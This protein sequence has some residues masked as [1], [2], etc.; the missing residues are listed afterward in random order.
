MVP[1]ASR[2]VVSAA[3]FPRRPPLFRK[4]KFKPVIIATCV[5]WYC[6]FSLRL[7]NLEELIAERGLGFRLMRSSLEITWQVLLLGYCWTVVRNT[8]VPAGC[9]VLALDSAVTKMSKFFSG[10][11]VSKLPFRFLSTRRRPCVW[12]SAPFS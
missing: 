4:R 7:R 11:D 3:P 9:L 6:R 12:G 2:P 10:V 1:W 8:S 5:R